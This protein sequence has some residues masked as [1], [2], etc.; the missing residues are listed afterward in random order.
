MEPAK[1]GTRFEGPALNDNGFI[2]KYPLHVGQAESLAALTEE[3]AFFTPASMYLHGSFMDGPLVD[4]C[5]ERSINARFYHRKFQ[6]SIFRGLEASDGDADWNNVL[7]AI[8]KEHAEPFYQFLLS[9]T[10]SF[11]DEKWY[12]QFAQQDFKIVDPL[13]LE[14]ATVLRTDLPKLSVSAF[15][16]NSNKVRTVFD[17]AADPLRYPPRLCRIRPDPE[18]VVAANALYE[19]KNPLN[20]KL[21]YRNEKGRQS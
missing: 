15:C 16:V 8:A 14:K 13:A 4:F 3:W 2:D 7:W 10:M 5:W 6:R 21:N 19:G 18:V 1:E 9:V 17:V 20:A 12:V 11:T